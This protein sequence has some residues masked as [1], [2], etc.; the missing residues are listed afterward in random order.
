MGGKTEKKKGGPTRAHTH[1]SLPCARTIHLRGW[2]LVEASSV[3]ATTAAPSTEASPTPATRPATEGAA[4]GAAPAPAPIASSSASHDFLENALHFRR[5]PRHGG[6]GQAASL[7]ACA[8]YKR[9]ATALCSLCK[10][11]YRWRVAVVVCVHRCGHLLR[12]LWLAGHPR[13][14]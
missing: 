10:H 3:E 6:G 8:H 12:I 9:S 2:A 11:P 14:G 13:A 1:T 5:F 7:D 4:P